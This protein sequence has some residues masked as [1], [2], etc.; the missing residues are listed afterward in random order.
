MS[1]SL[2][3]FEHVV[4]E[5]RFVER[6]RHFGDEDR[7]VGE[8]IRLRLVRE[9]ALHRVPELVRERAD[10]VVLPVVVDQHVRVDVV[11]TALRVGARTL[12][13]VGQQIDPSLRE[14]PLDLAW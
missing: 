5:Q 2:M 10:V 6:G 7:V 14:R 3:F 1:S 4:D 12:A 13:V 11:G 8:R 9:V